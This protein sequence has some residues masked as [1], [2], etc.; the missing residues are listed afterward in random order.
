M[1]FNEHMIR[2]LNND[3]MAQFCENPAFNGGAIGAEDSEIIGSEKNRAVDGGAMYL[4]S[5][6]K[7]ILIVTS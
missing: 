6:S 5:D 2:I 1:A 7:L 4:D 3:T